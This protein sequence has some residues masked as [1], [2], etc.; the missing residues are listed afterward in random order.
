MEMTD[1]VDKLAA[2]AQETRLA[3]FR[4]LV[5][6][7]PAGLPAGRIGEEMGIPPATLSFHL[8]Q[9]TRVGLLRSRRESRS[10]FYAVD[11]AS[12]K[13]LLDYMTENCCGAGDATCAPAPR[14]EGRR[15]G[16]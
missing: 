7:G 4:L 9:L 12:I 6:Y 8:A 14:K 16:K 13:G 15:A 10:I 2:L 11:F 3:V 1:A 5:Q